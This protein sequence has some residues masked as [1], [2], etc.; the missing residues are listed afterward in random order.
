MKN[1]GGLVLAIASPGQ[2]SE[3]V[4][5]GVAVGEEVGRREGVSEN[6][7]GASAVDV[8]AV[9][10]GHAASGRAAVVGDSAEASG[11]GVAGGGCGGLEELAELGGGARSGCGGSVGGETAAVADGCADGRA[12]GTGAVAL[13]SSALGELRDCGRDSG[14]LLGV[15]I[16]RDGFARVGKDISGELGGAF[17]S[18]EE[19]TSG[20]DGVGAGLGELVQL[21][22]LDLNLDGLAGLDGLENLLREVGVG[23]TLE[24]TGERCRGRGRSDGQLIDWRIVKERLLVKE[25]VVNLSGIGERDL[26]LAVLGVGEFDGERRVLLCKINSRRADG[27]GQNGEA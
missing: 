24:K 11:D 10:T 18:I 26:D 27:G 6:A 21:S 15:D 5:E 1:G 2:G 3:L 20:R 8:G 4:E 13:D 22:K 19:A 16:N 12:T 9:G 14:S 7:G 17:L 25:L 23:H